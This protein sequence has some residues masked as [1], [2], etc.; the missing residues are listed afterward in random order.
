MADR[1]RGSLLLNSSVCH[2]EEFE[3]LNPVPG[4]A[5]PERSKYTSKARARVVSLRQPAVV[6]GDEGLVVTHP[7]LYLPDATNRARDAYSRHTMQYFSGLPSLPSAIRELLRGRANDFP[8]AVL[9]RHVYDT[10]YYHAVIDVLGGLALI[11]R[12]SGLDNQPIL[13]SERLWK[14]SFFRETVT[15]GRLAELNWVVQARDCKVGELCFAIPH[16]RDRT[17]LEHLRDMIGREAEAGRLPTNRVFVGRGHSA[18]RCIANMR[19]VRAVLSA[20]DFD[21]VEVEGL[22]VAQQAHLFSSARCIVAIHGAALANLIH[23]R[24]DTTWVLE[25]LS[26]NLPS[27]LYWELATT[28]GM[29]YSWLLGHSPDGKESRSNFRI[30][31]RQLDSELARILEKESSVRVAQ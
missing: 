1:G 31:T 3:A 30:D 4:I 13:V 25:I 12:T 28:L 11:D 29:E 21:Y 16:A 23:A 7:A 20:Y 10:N 27:L 26:P 9:A 5:D 17:S 2:E 18:G 22:S 19:E 14:S 15:S 24:P 8:R 6:E